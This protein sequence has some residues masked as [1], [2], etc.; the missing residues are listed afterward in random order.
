LWATSSA[1]T[2]ISAFS[3]SA[4]TYNT[5]PVNLFAASYPGA[6]NT[7][8]RT[9]A[10]GR[11]A[12][13]SPNNGHFYWLG[14]SDG[15]NANDGVVEVFAASATG[16]T[17]TKVGSL[18]MNGAS[19]NELGFV[20]LAVG[21]EGTAWILAGDGTTLILA[22]FLTNGVNPTTI[23]VEDAS[24]TLSG[25][26]VSTF[27]NG[28]ICLSGNGN[29]YALA[30]DG[31][32]VTQLF[33]GTPAGANTTL[34]KRLDLVD[35]NNAVFTGSVN[36][37]AFDLIGSIYLST[38]AG[39]YYINK[40]T[41]NTTAATVQC[42]LVRAVTGLQDLA[43]NVWPQNAILPVNLI[44]FTA[45]YNNGR[46]QLNWESADEVN[47]SHYEVERMSDTRRGY[48]TVAQKMAAG[49]SG[50]NNYQALD[51]LSSVFETAIYYRLKMVDVN[52]T[53]KYSP[54]VLVRKEKKDLSTLLISPN[55]ISLGNTQ[56]TLHFYSGQ[57][58]QIRVR[59]LDAAGRPVLQQ[60]NTI[61]EG[62]NSVSLQNMH[63]LQ[64]GFYLIQL[65][66][67]AS[68]STTRLVVSK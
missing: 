40:N 38:S 4:G 27:Q 62:T 41:L 25:G 14:T 15:G 47:F 37:V 44:S 1:G 52:G 50:R 43:S 19:A 48:E 23:T 68:I 5:G 30:N 46:T 39:L 51:D 29:I 26:A 9:A 11:N 36:G 32:G 49:N 12:S 54:V 16:G 33:L 8:T 66:Q 58:D 35:E 10:L 61:N 57:A 17:P 31:N 21:P 42:A 24:V 3:V 34:T 65:Q 13:P 64:S 28:D 45:T 55:P 53:F 63:Q 7:Y 67:G 2:Q 18:D 22:K 60:V 20:R 59:V 56:A 6:N